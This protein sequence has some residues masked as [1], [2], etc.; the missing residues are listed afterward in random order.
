MKAD[1]I[2][3]ALN[4][5]NKENIKPFD[6]IARLVAKSYVSS[7][8]QGAPFW[9]WLLG[10]R[11]TSYFWITPDGKRYLQAE[12]VAADYSDECQTGDGGTAEDLQMVKDF[13]QQLGYNL[14][15]YGVAV[16]LLSLTSGYSHCETASHLAVLTLALDV[17]EAGDDAGKLIALL[18][19]GHFMLDVL[20][21]FNNENLMREEIWKNDSQAIFHISMINENQKNFVQKILI[22]QLYSRNRLANLLAEYT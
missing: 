2:E 11:G 6:S 18:S 20:K 15:T 8:Y 7:G 13:L 3:I 9:R 10:R 22:S 21:E 16:S 5:I 1:E 4:E 17:Q 19:H 14:T 12:Q